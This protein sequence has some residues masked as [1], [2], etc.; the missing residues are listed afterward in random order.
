MQAK[1]FLTSKP[2]LSNTQSSLWDITTYAASKPAPA[3]DDFDYIVKTK[4]FDEAISIAKNTIKNDTLTDLYTWYVFNGM[5]YGFLNEK[6]Y[7]EAISIF[8]LNTEL[9][10]NDANLFDSLAEAYELSGDKER[11]KT[12]SVA[13]IEMLDKK[14]SLSDFEKGLKANAEKRLN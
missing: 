13:V 11:M 12:T 2:T 5:G 6:K 14:G 3:K 9:H 7:K 1:T 10:P 8:K 4:G